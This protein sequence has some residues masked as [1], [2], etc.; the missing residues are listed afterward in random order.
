[1]T[2]REEEL[3]P[4]TVRVKA[5]A[6]RPVPESGTLSGELTSLLVM[7][8][9]PVRGSDAVG[10]KVMPTAQLAPAART[11]VVHGVVMA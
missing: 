7:V 8:S 11:V 9:E 6:A 4:L 2:V 5:P 3:A 1:V 10:E